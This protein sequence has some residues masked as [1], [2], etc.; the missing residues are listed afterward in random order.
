MRRGASGSAVHLRVKLGSNRSANGLRLT[1]YLLFW[2]SSFVFPAVASSSWDQAKMRWRLGVFAGCSLPATCT[3]LSV[4]RISSSHPN[5]TP[6]RWPLRRLAGT[7]SL[8]TFQSI[9]RLRRSA[10]TPP[11]QFEQDLE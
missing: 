7:K 2:F 1:F 3:C 8:R 10:S 4:Y 9:S 5:M 11:E 6:S